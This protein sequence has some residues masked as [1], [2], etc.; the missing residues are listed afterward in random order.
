LGDCQPECP[1]REEAAYTAGLPDQHGAGSTVIT[2]PHL[3]AAAAVT[4]C[5]EQRAVHI[6]QI[7]R[8]G[9]SIVWVDIPDEDGAVGTAIALPQLTAATVIK[10]REEQRAVDV[11]QIERAVI[12]A[13]RSEK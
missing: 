5:E 1:N 2:P 7:V 8:A 6:C 10:G 9:S 12:E 11:G 13:T 3:S 4:G